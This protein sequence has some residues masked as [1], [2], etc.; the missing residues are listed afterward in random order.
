M[1]IYE[2][3]C[4]NCEK[5]IEVFLRHSDDEPHCPQCGNLLS[6]KLFSAPNLIVRGGTR[7]AG[8]CPTGTCQLDRKG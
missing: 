1:P 8:S 2:Y 7:S 4:E 5:Q 6:K 3:L